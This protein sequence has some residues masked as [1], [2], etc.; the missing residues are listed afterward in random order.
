MGISMSSHDNMVETHRRMYL[1]TALETQRSAQYKLG[2][3]RVCKRIIEKL[4]GY[5]KLAISPLE[6]LLA[7]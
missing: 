7:R 1:T 6:A 2:D 5:L 3:H 4:L